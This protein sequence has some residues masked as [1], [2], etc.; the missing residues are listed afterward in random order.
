MAH[1]G[2]DVEDTDFLEWA[3]FHK[4]VILLNGGTSNSG[5]ES[6]YGLEPR[7]GS[8]ENHLESLKENGIKAVPFYEPDLNYSLSSI[9][10]IVDERVYNRTKYPDYTPL[11]VQE[12]EDSIM[13]TKNFDHFVEAKEC[14]ELSQSFL[15]WVESIGGEKNLFLRLY[16][17]HI[18]LAR[19]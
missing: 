4:T 11:D 10:F 12:V 2:D 3:K 6:Y 19:N 7:K 13:T 8:M 15:N 9:D 16:V 5:K 14:G 18:P 1:A 17:N